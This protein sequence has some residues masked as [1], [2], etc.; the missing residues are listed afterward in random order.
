MPPAC[1]MSG[2]PECAASSIQLLSRFVPG[3]TPRNFG[4]FAPSGLTSA[5]NL[6]KAG[7]WRTKIVQLSCLADPEH[8]APFVL[9]A[10][11][12]MTVSGAI[13]RHIAQGGAI[14]G[15]QLHLRSRGEVLQPLVETQHRQWTVQA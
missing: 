10:F 11:H 9:T 5:Q 12:A 7:P 13:G 1:K 2:P 3:R 8:Q 14:R 15:P 4:V 6:G